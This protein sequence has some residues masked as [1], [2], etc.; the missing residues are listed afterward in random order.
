MHAQSEQRRTASALTYDQMLETVRYDGA[1]PTRERAEQAVHAV[2]AALGGQLGDDLRTALAAHLPRRAA[3]I[4]AAQAPTAQP[5]TGWSFVQDIAART[6]VT[7]A[8]A[9]WD[10]GA[11]LSTVAALLPGDLLTRTISE[12]PAGYALLFGRAELARAA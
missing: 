4:L 6:G 5:R 10:T 7:P 11:V 9:R 8:V 12:L 1:Y 3:D 2:L